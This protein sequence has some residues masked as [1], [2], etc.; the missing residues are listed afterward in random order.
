MCDLLHLR[1][2]NQYYARDSSSKVIR[3]L[4]MQNRLFVILML[5]SWLSRPCVA[6]SASPASR[7]VRA[8]GQQT[9]SAAQSATPA[10]DISDGTK[11]Q[12][13]DLTEEVVRD[14]LSNLQKGLECHDLRQ[15]LAIFDQHAMNNY[16]A[17]RNQL[18]AFFRQ[19]ETVQFRYQILQATADKGSGFA[20]AD[21][22]MDAV[23]PDNSQV[24]LRRTLQMRFRIKLSPKG[25]KVTGFTP[26]DFFAQ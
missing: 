11:V 16:D 4:G 2:S 26:S 14:I 25:W 9:S 13:L 1:R 17:V 12:D 19:Y 20:T 15:V 18:T 6:A 7:T 24:P 5:L 3:R 22:D 10:D 8:S 23:T 21:I